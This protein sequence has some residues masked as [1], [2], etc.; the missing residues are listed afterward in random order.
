[1]E[2]CLAT[3]W[4]RAQGTA[5]MSPSRYGAALRRGR[6]RRRTDAV[7][8]VVVVGGGGALVVVVAAAG[9]VDV[10]AAVFGDAVDLHAPAGTGSVADAAFVVDAVLVAFVR[11]TCGDV[12]AGA[13]LAR[14][15]DAP[16]SPSRLV[17]PRIQHQHQHQ[18]H[19]QP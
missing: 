2:A 7:A 19:H 15:V 3:G 12:V 13:L 8:A 16:R 18:H 5:A 6:G 4:D 1:M 9:V 17:P 14:G 10:V 11:G